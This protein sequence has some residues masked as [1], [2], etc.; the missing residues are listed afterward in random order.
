MADGTVR[1]VGP[2][3]REVRV[4]VPG[5]QTTRP[6]SPGEGFFFDWSP[7][8]RSLIAYPSEAIGHAII[9]DTVDG[10]WRGARSASSMRS[11]FPLVA[12][13]QRLAP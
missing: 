3:P 5:S 13:W 7:D 1:S 6:A 8:G 4:A 11:G 2:L 9:I 10:T 12:G